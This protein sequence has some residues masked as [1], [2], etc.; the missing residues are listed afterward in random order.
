MSVFFIVL[1]NNITDKITFIMTSTSF[2][3]NPLNKGRN[4]K[5][6]DS[7]HSAL[8]VQVNILKLKYIFVK[9]YYLACFVEKKFF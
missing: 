6:I 8:N 7:R 9:R 3:L 5:E 2:K 4:R 1:D